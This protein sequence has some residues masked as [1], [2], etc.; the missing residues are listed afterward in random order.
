[1]SFTVIC[2]DKTHIFFF[3]EILMP[4]KHNFSHCPFVPHILNSP[5]F[6]YPEYILISLVDHTFCSL[7]KCIFE[8]KAFFLIHFFWCTLY[9]LYNYCRSKF[10]LSKCLSWRNMLDIKYLAIAI[11]Y[12]I[13]FDGYLSKVPLAFTFKNT[14]DSNA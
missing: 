2:Q 6:S 1:M 12:K 9:L 13:P 3:F 10:F 5:K 7:L 8:I 14:S 4:E 11:Y